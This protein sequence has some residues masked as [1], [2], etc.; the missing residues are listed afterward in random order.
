MLLNRKTV[1]QKLLWLAAQAE[2]LVKSANLR[3][4]LA[5][6][7]EFDELETIEHT[8]CKPVSILVAVEQKSRR[9]LA[10]GVARMPA[11]GKLAKISVKKYGIRVDER[12]QVREQVF[13]ELRPLI[14]PSAVLKSDES[15]HYPEA[16]KEHFPDCEHRTFKSRRACAAGQG[17]LKK[18]V[19]DPIFSINHTN[20]MLRANINRLIRRTWCTTKKPE[21]LA[22]HL[23]IYA[24]YHNFKII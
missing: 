19:F 24:A 4:P 16:V 5:T 18:A 12:K 6:V 7:I 10:F 20:A 2:E 1:V 17:E 8:K 22:A 9:I 13:R 23:A 14:V 3:H 21:R 15:P 11:K